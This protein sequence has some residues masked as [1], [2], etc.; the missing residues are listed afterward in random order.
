MALKR[1]LLGPIKR[2]S[3]ANRAYRRSVESLRVQIARWSQSQRERAV[4]RLASDLLN[5]RRLASFTLARQFAQMRSRLRVLCTTDAHSSDIMWDRYADANRGFRI[6]L[7]TSALEQ[8]WLVPAERVTYSDS[9]PKFIDP[10]VFVDQVRRG[11]QYDAATDS[12]G[13]AWCLSKRMEWAC[14]HEWRFASLG[15]ATNSGTIDV[16]IPPGALTAI[17]AGFNAGEDDIAGVRDLLRQHSPAPLLTRCVVD[18][19]RGERS[20]QAL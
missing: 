18:R 8:A 16:K 7:S 3:I 14:E 13:R 4:E 1:D 9:P 12:M 19:I 17:E 5:D 11:S 10:H 15:S 6:S 2:S 20:S